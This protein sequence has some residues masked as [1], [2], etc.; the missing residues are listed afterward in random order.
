VLI[1]Y[2]QT[3]GDA[4]IFAAR[5]R[6]RVDVNQESIAQGAAN[7]GAGL[8]QGMPVSTSLSASSLNDSSGARTQMASI[9]TGLTVLAT[10]LLIAPLFRYL[11]KPILAVVIIDAVV[12][13]M[14]DL[15]EMKR[16][17]A[18]KRVDF[19]IA[20]AALLAV[21]AAGVLAGVLI[22]IGLSI[23]W[24]V[25]VNTHP[26][27]LELGRRPNSSAFE[28]LDVQPDGQTFPGVLVLRFM[29]GLFFAT[30]DSL[31]DRL[32]QA[33]L[34]DGAVPLRVVVIDFGGA[35]FI[36]SQGAAT[37][38]EIVLTGRR[39]GID[40][41]VARVQPDVLSVLVAE[42]AIDAIGADHVH[43]NLD[44][45]VAETLGAWIDGSAASAPSSDPDPTAVG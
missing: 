19:W 24:L 11:P 7:L 1:G 28:P 44:E 43:H 32:R 15:P 3:A 39:N 42:G 27:T 5:H 40:V 34:A 17:W 2:S 30:A 9:V 8:F 36:D 45:A 23:L 31:Q 14:M 6:Y 29:A 41:R 12:Y 20:V 37:F 10:L 33:A 25:Y 4:R 35:N 16:M 18:V 21:L 38:K 22:G 26:S 13:G